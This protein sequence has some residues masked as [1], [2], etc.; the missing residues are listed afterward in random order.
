MPSGGTSRRG[1][2]GLEVG[3]GGV[4]GHVIGGG[5]SEFLTIQGDVERLI[6]IAAQLFGAIEREIRDLEAALSST[7]SD[8]P[9]ATE[10]T[11]FKEQLIQ[12]SLHLDS[13]L[14]QIARDL[15]QGL[16]ALS[17]VPASSHN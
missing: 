12:S 16:G 5:S 2:S 14:R 9:W 17:H 6:G 13:S 1:G 3:H 7:A 11:L 15:G 10:R 8:R 4:A